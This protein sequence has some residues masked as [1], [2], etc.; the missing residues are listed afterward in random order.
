M[1]GFNTLKPGAVRIASVFIISLLFAVTA[2][3]YTVVMRGGRSIEIPS[4][5]VVT[6]A[7]LT[8]EVAQGIQITLAMAAIDIPATE[9]AN[10]EQP[11]SLLRR[12]QAGTREPAA[13]SAVSIATRTIT[14]RDLESS[15]RRRRES[16]LAYEIRRKQ[17]GLP[18]L[19]ESRRQAAALP[20]L[21]GTELERKLVAEKESEDY[22]RARASALRTE[23]AA[24]DAELSYL[25]ARLDEISTRTGTGSSFSA[26]IFLPLISGGN[27]GGSHSFPRAA[28]RRPNVF[29]TPGTPMSGRAG[30]GRGVTPGLIFLN[31][32]RF[33][34]RRTLG[35]G[36][37]VAFPGGAIYGHIGHVGQPYDYSYERSALITQ[38]NEL[39]AARAGLNAMWRELEDEARRA[40]ASP[41]WLRR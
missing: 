5:F 34:L 26:S 40:G 14:N 30:F 3:A 10:N 28:M 12:A 25:R 11:G 41:G 36:P 35:G 1:G 37:N 18:T 31:P 19:E 23:T 21:R 13:S 33:P 38:F 20:D 15:V 27:V 4:R 24:L 32:G 22:W 9:R 7:T 39:A 17:L 29:G 6:A 2:S 16:E 8:Y